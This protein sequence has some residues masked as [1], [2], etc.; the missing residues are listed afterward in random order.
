MLKAL[1]LCGSLRAGS[2]NR[3]LQQ[4]MDTYLA[5]RGVEVTSIDLNDYPLP[6]FN[7]DVE[8]AHMPEPA[9]ALGKLFVEADII[10]IASP[11]YNASMTP[12]TKNTLDWV[13]RQKGRPFRHA[14]FGIGSV[15]SGKLSG[16]V[17]LAHLRDVLSK[18]MALVAPT[19]LR[20]GPAEGA[21][22]EDG[23]FTEEAMRNRAGLLADDLVLLG[24][25][26]AARRA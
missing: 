21:F 20:V 6:L 9:V 13:S 3:R 15:S 24:Q 2:S 8:D 14:V 22:A 7:E 19:D 17:N 1:T 16:V 11:E 12:L 10:F 23:D 5:Q 18:V 25:G 4:L 26:M